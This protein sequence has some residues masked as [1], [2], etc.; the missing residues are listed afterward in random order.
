MTL[1]DTSA[2]NGLE[3]GFAI[4][5][6]SLFVGWKESWSP[7]M[8]L[9]GIFVTFPPFSWFFLLYREHATNLWCFTKL[10][11]APASTYRFNKKK[12]QDVKYSWTKRIFDSSQ[13]MYN[14]IFLK[15]LSLLGNVA[16]VLRS[17]TIYYNSSSLVYTTIFFL[18]CT[19]TLIS[20][21]NV[22]LQINVGPGKNIKT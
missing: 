17:Y 20:L 5:S 10:S 19:S 11:R 7:M 13:F 3:K 6:K 2:F 1:I 14:K 18:S 9:E 22:G 8:A 15:K 21:I 12:I 16:W 4:T